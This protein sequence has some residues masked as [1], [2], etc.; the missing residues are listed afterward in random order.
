VSTPTV[1]IVVVPRERFS[2]ARRSLESVY[3]NTDYPFELIYVD[4]NSPPHLQQYLQQEAADRRFTLV[5]TAHF[6]S[7]NQA[8]NI[9][10]KKVQTE[11]VVFLDND[12]E[13]AP[14]WLTHLVECAEDTGAW[15]VSPV[16]FEGTTKS[17]V[18]HTAGGIVDFEDTGGV[19]TIRVVHHLHEVPYDKARESLRR[20]ATGFFE[21]HCVMVRLEVFMRLGPLDEELLSL[22]E[23]LDLSLMIQQA[24]GTVFLE[25]EAHVTYVYGL[26]NSSDVEYARVRWCDEWNRRSTMQFLRKWKMDEGSPWGA[27]VIDFGAVHRRHLE[28]LRRSPVRLLKHAAKNIL[29]KR[30]YTALR[31]LRS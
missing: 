11:Y 7:P 18:V 30:V 17:R 31:D 9:G 28:N 10:M 21:F 13:V 15:A 29:P 12:V 2:H 5:R 4:G 24:G 20:E 19:R 8:R 14:G 1:T 3:R 22:H 16:Y 25:P 27:S 26:L 23:H 6:L